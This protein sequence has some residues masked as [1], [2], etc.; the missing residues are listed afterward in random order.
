[1][2]ILIYGMQSSGASTLAFLLAQKPDC[3]AFIDIWAMYAAP[4]LPGTG[5]VV[6]KVVVTTAF[7]LALHQERFRPD[8]TVLFLRHPVANRGS[9]STKSYRHHCGFMEEKFRLLDAVFESRSGFDAVLCYED[10]IYDTTGMLQSVSQLGWACD[11][12]VRFDR[13]PAEIQRFNEQ[14][15]PMVMDRLEYGSGN[16]HWGRLDPDFVNLPESSDADP[17]MREWCPAVTAHYQHLLQHERRTV[18]AR[19]KPE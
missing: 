17:D 9:L 11:S 14:R 15:Y 18:W 5:D 19:A 2:R 10:L 16:H 1:M 4:S 13:N 8:C 12:N 7:P 3:A 6:A